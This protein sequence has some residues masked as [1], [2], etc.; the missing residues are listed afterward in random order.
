MPRSM[1]TGSESAR[2]VARYAVVLAGGYGTRFW[3]LSRRRVPKQFLRVAGRRSMLQET[4]RRV[5]ALVPASHIIVVAARDFAPQIRRQLPALPRQRLL[6][7]PAKRGTA[8]CIAL[9]AEWIARRAPNAVMAVFPSDHVISDEGAFRRAAQVAFDTAQRRRCLVTFGITPVSAETGYGYLETG[10]LLRR[11]RPRAFWVKRFHE[12]P[13]PAVAACYVAAAGRYLWNSGMFVWRVDV[14]REA[15]AR[16]TPAIAA[17]ARDG[18][19][20]AFR[21]LQSTSVDV[22]ILERAEKVA[23][24]EG[25]FGWSDVGSWAALAPVWGVDGNGNATRGRA[26]LVDTHDSLVFGAQRLVAVVGMSDVA[27]IEAPDALLVCRKSRAQD[28]RR[29]VDELARRHP[30]LC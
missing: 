7:E 30:R 17:A 27:V 9:A 16:L 11:Q 6:I 5:R 21:R 4:V 23:V 1:P 19:V 24:V 13:T 10:S 2:R 25:D 18:G 8:A 3:P 29:L 12:K 28:V 14:I 26:I 15:F 22:A 20:R